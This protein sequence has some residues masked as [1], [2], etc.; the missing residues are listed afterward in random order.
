MLFRSGLEALDYLGGKPGGAAWAAGQKSLLDRAKQPQAELL[1]SILPA[2]RD[3]VAAA[4][5]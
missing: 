3:L 4:G 5:K 2:V 1:I